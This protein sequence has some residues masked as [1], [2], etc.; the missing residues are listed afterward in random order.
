MTQSYRVTTKRMIYGQ[1]SG[2]FSR[3]FSDMSEA[4]DFADFMMES[5][6]EGN[7]KFDYE[8]EIVQVVRVRSVKRKIQEAME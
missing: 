5:Y 3:E 8:V 2:T 7:R 6:M 4:E 1:I